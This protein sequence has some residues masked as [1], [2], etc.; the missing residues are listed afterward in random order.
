MR[1]T[2]SQQ[3]PILQS[4]FIT[5]FLDQIFHAL[6]T[7]NANSFFF[8]RRRDPLC[9]QSPRSLLAYISPIRQ[10]QGHGHQPDC[11]FDEPEL[12]EGRVEPDRPKLHNPGI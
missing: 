2:R 4:H 7:Q 5:F 1:H 10:D 12:P 6:Q 11:L 8:R 9:G 3:V